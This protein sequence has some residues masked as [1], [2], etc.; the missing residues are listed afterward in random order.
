M[1]SQEQAT[2]D[3]LLDK[4]QEAFVL[5]LEIYNRPSIRYRVEGFSFFICNAWEL[6]L[7]ARIISTHGITKIYFK[8]NPSR[9][10][11]LE[12][13][14]ALV[15]TNEK[16][17]LRKNLTDIIH[18]RNTS[19]HFIVE[20]HEQI[21]CG[22]FQSCVNNFDEKMYEYHG[23]NLSDIVPA[24]FLTL[25]M[26]ADPAN[27]DTIRAKYSPDIA[28]RFLF[29]EAQ[30]EQEQL[31]QDNLRYSTVMVTELAIVK[32][33][34]NAD[35]TVAYDN[36]SDKRI[37]TAKIFQDPRNTHP[38]SVK[39]IVEH[40]NKRLK[41]S[42]IILRASGEA[43]DFTSS[44]WAL[45]MKF[46]DLKNNEEY[47]Y[48]HKYGKTDLHTYSMKTVDFIVESISRDPDNIIDELKS[49][50]KKQAR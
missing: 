30:I 3:R 10:I 5:A 32:N 26:T 29:D 44:D 4:A 8:D 13:C 40:V 17:P 20:E 19:T 39:N 1:D 21:Y 12:R 7:K 38:L 36:A 35:F 6:M 23:R 28:E 42:G 25:S 31:L 49:L 41:R 37:R 2:Y 9:T 22:L 50:M 33:P 18:L 46:Y 48:C 15:F 11:N 45:F 24:H 16:D 43:K 47:G 27:P 34:K 14:I